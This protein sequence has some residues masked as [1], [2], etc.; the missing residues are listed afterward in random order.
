MAE[1]FSTL[2]IDNIGPQWTG[3]TT[4]SGPINMINNP[5]N[6]LP[7]PINTGDAANKAY[8]DSIA[9]GG[10]SLVGDNLQ[11]GYIPVVENATTLT[12]NASVNPATLNQPLTVNGAI[13]GTTI[14]ASTS[15]ITPTLSA[16][17]S[18]TS[19]SITSTGSLS[20]N[21]LNV[22]GTSTLAGMTVTYLSSTGAVT[23]TSGQINGNLNVTGTTT[24]NIL[25]STS[26]TTSG[27]TNT[28]S[29]AVNGTS[30]FAPGGTTVL[31]V[32]S[33]SI[34]TNVPVQINALDTPEASSSFIVNG[35]SS[36]IGGN[37]YPAVFNGLASA[38]RVV[39]VISNNQSTGSGSISSATFYGPYS[40]A[41]GAKFWEIGNDSASNGTDQMYVRSNSSGNVIYTI[42][43]AGAMALAG[44]LNVS[45]G[46]SSPL[47]LTG[48]SSTRTAFS[49][50]NTFGTVGA[51]SIATG[52]TFGPV[53]GNGIWQIGNDSN[54]NGTDDFF[55]YSST[56]G[57][58]IFRLTPTSMIVNKA[59]TVNS[60]ANIS[61]LTTT[62]GLTTTGTLTAPSITSTSAAVTISQPT[63]INASTN[64]NGTLTVSG[65]SV[66]TQLVIN[67]NATQPAILLQM[68][69][70]SGTK[71][72]LT[73]G[74]TYAWSLNTDRGNTGS[75]QA[76]IYSATAANDIEIWT[77]TGI[78]MNQPLTLPY[79]TI[80]A[81]AGTVNPGSITT[82][83]VDSGDNLRFGSNIVET[84]ASGVIDATYTI[85]STTQPT[86][87]AI[88][89]TF[90]LTISGKNAILS[91]SASS[92]SSAS[93]SNAFKFALTG[94]IPSAY[95]PYTTY[96]WPTFV[97]NNGTIVQ[98][99]ANYQTGYIYFATD[100]VSW[101][102]TAGTYTTCISYS[103]T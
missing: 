91:I 52:A 81:Q 48:N 93:G 103:I 7:T 2:S 82:L 83:W 68:T 29:L 47:T 12:T 57:I 97:Y 67:G 36:V 22:T 8:V 54:Q 28:G 27:S 95:L 11:V 65:S 96:Y 9:H 31:T 69:P 92:G 34:S 18:M 24:T 19:P 14:T 38:S 20:S 15:M 100:G 90:R 72:S 66:P 99:T 46:A 60:T 61:G 13:N 6:N 79:Q 70:Y 4:F 43:P 5:I 76:S 21:T 78:T 26:T 53:G 64:V 62:N 37:V 85:T 73:M 39:N 74:G 102:G 89:V 80:T 42:S 50:T 17:T 30:T 32:N 51:S 56:A 45:S 41:A 84:S 63:T 71:N 58:Q 44:T 77:P 35:T 49:I 86:T 10:A 101:S 40:I 88:T 25:S 33:G 3:S 94:N 59:L 16:T 98:G 87:A 75:N 55:W 1:D 23:A